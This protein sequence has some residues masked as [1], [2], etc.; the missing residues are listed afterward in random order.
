VTYPRQQTAWFSTS[1]FADPLAPWNG[2]TTQ[3]F[4]TAGKD[5]VV[6]PRL[7]NFN[8]SLVK[9]IQLTAHEGPGIELR[10]ESFNTFNHTQFSGLNANSHDSNFG[11][12]TSI[13]GARILELGGRLHF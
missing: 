8:L 3:G 10:F 13:Y 5:A 6:L 9:N 12:I 11:Q 7:V 1:S 4:G 2:G